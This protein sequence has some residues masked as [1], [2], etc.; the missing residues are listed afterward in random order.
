MST[1]YAGS[2]PVDALTLISGFLSFFF[3]MVMWLNKEF[4]VHPMKLVMLC[5]FSEAMMAF[6]LVTTHF[7]CTL[8]LPQFFALSIFKLGTDR[9][10]EEEIFLLRL[11]SNFI[12]IFGSFYILLGL[13]LNFSLCLDLIIL[14]RSPFKAV[15]RRE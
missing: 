7:V 13:A 8:R 15:Q 2:I 3:A 6:H 9:N 4:D 5:I 1:K 11:F 10:Y 12:Q 14:F